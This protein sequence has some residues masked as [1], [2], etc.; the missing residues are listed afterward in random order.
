MVEVSP[1]TLLKTI[2]NL[3]KSSTNETM[4]NIAK[5]EIALIRKSMLGR[6]SLQSIKTTTE[7]AR[8]TSIFIIHLELNICYQQFNQPVS[9]ETQCIRGRDNRTNMLF[10]SKEV[11]RIIIWLIS[12]LRVKVPN[13]LDPSA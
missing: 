11:D 6:G 1:T 12:I 8:R 10:S 4:T 9:S 13:L 3:N 5:C 2:F 7:W